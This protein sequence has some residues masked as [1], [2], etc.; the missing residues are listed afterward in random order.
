METIYEVLKNEHDEVLNLFEEA[1]SSGS[2]D[3]FNRIKSELQPHLA[4]EEEVYYPIIKEKHELREIT[5]EAFE[6]H[7]VAKVLLSELEKMDSSDERW[8]AK[9]KVLKEGVKHH[10][11]EEQN[12]MFEKS[13]KVLSQDKAE[14]IAQKYLEFKKRFKQQHPTP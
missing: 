7:H 3:T 1:L 13:R 10:I 8:H 5:L 11:D 2:K 14:E 6:E 9:L 12:E 4:G